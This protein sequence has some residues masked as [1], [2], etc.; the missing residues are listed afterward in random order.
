MDIGKGSLWL[1]SVF[2]SIL[3]ATSQTTSSGGSGLMLV[4]CL[5]LCKT[6]CKPSG[7]L[8]ALPIL[9][10]HLHLSNSFPVLLSRPFPCYSVYISGSNYVLVSFFSLASPDIFSGDVRNVWNEV[11]RVI[12]KTSEVS[13]VLLINVWFWSNLRW[14]I[15]CN[16]H[17]LRFNDHFFHPFAELV[18]KFNVMY[19]M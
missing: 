10:A 19:V 12:I 9:H 14:M 1:C 18:T 4:S 16:L 6:L 5:L 7:P 17:F 8:L 13:K 11:T 15:Y 3:T 2:R